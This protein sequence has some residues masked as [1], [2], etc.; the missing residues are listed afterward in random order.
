MKPHKPIPS[1]QEMRVRALVGR[2][3]KRREIA[4]LA[5]AGKITIE[6]AKADLKAVD[7]PKPEESQDGGED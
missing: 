6:E 3:N 1:P 4:D 2:M 7:E 5:Q